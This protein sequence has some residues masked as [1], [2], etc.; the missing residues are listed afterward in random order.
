MPTVQRN[1]QYGPRFEMFKAN[2]NNGTTNNKSSIG[3]PILNTDVYLLSPEQR[4][5]TNQCCRGNRSYIGSEGL[6][7][8]YVNNDDL[9]KE[10]FIEHPFKAESVCIAA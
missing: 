3:K 4:L 8:G 1:I 7:A 10:K 6:A 2:E 9:T 5:G